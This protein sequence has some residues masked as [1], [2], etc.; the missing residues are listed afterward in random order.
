MDEPTTALDVTTQAR[1]LRLLDSLKVDYGMSVLFITHNLGVLAQICD[2]VAVMY[3]G[4]MAEV[5]PT[6]ELFK[7]P[8]HPYTRGLIAAVP[9]LNRRNDG[10]EKLEGLLRRGELPNGCR[11]APR[12]RYSDP[13]CF[14][15][16]QTLTAVGKDHQAACWRW[17]H[18]KEAT[19]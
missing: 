8:R 14:S 18:V 3:A 17:Q 9:Q 5:A 1:I 11:F 15:E 12:C 16:S 7:N 13:K 2:R 4:E 6:A 19:R 10:K